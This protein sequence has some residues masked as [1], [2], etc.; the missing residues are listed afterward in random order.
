MTDGNRQ[1]ER[2]AA[3]LGDSVSDEARERAAALIEPQLWHNRAGRIAEVSARD[4]PRQ[5]QRRYRRLADEARQ[6][7]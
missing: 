1:V 5:A 6:A 2:I 3:F 7:G 4:V